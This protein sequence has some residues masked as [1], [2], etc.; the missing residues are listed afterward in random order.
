MV[1]REQSTK[2]AGSRQRRIVG[3]GGQVVVVVVMVD[4]F[5]AVA[6]YALRYD[7]TTRVERTRE[8]NVQKVGGVSVT[9]NKATEFG[10]ARS[11]CVVVVFKSTQRCLRRC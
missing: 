10:L 9:N 6:V 8:R 4:E 3:E 2:V 5:D 11:F 7:E 1:K